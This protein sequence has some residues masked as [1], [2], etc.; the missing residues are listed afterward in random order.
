MEIGRRLE[1]RG[2][3]YKE[4]KQIWCILFLPI[5]FAISPKAK[6]V[7]KCCCP[8]ETPSSSKCCPSEAPEK[9]DIQGSSSLLCV[10]IGVTLY[11][12]R[13]RGCSFQQGYFIETNKQL[14][15]PVYIR[16]S[17]EPYTIN[18]Q[19]QIRGS[20]QERWWFCVPEFV[21]SYAISSFIIH[22]TKF[23]KHFQ[24]AKQCA[25]KWEARL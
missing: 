4:A 9:S 25:K 22:Q 6:R 13:V 8:S 15:W 19:P 18:L 3:G 10:S 16:R 1:S 23:S 5:T 20:R 17:V 14:S 2:F 11:Q 21:Y 7:S 12:C 24:W